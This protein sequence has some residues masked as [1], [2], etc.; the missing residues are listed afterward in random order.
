MIT[1]RQIREAR[2]KLDRLPGELAKRAGLALSIIRRAEA[3]DGEAVIT[4]AQ[5]A[6]LRLTFVKAGVEFG[7]E[8][9]GETP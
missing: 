6:V 8:I 5:I 1:G 3:T 2:G 4:T 9:G 7:P